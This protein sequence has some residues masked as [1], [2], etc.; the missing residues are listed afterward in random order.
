MQHR[1]ESKFLSL[2]QAAEEFPISRRTLWGLIHEGKFPAFRLGRKLILR[3]EDVERFLTSTPVKV[4]LDEIVEECV[5]EV[6]GG[7]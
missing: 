1:I 5:R 2:R 3:R 7:D 6:A 4:D